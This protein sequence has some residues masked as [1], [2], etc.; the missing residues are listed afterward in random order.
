MA[1]LARDLAAVETDEPASE[2]V[3]KKAVDAA[4]VERARAGLPPLSSEP[5]PDEEQFY[6]RARALGLRRVRG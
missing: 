2:A 5:V 3:L 6:A 4:N 1:A